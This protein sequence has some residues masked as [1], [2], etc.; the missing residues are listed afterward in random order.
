M[1]RRTKVTAVTLLVAVPAFVLGPVVFPVSPQF[2]SPSPFQMPFL[3][4]L[5]VFEA[6]LLGLGVA[7]AVYGWPAVR[8]AVP[9]S[10][11]LAVATHVSLVWL[12]ANWWAHTGM[13]LRNG[14]ELGGLIFIDYAFHVPIVAAS[15][16]VAAALVSRVRQEIRT[17]AHAAR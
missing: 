9:S 6:V 17:P 1:R 16:I 5:S 8:A 2:P 4:A 15:L 3:L 13:H 12:M 10:R 14:I 11:R 7:F